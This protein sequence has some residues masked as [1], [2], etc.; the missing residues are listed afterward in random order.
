M[1]Y[2]KKNRD[3]KI[4]L[5]EADKELQ[6]KGDLFLKLNDGIIGICFLILFHENLST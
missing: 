2:I 4:I 1:Y 3:R 5:R 6:V